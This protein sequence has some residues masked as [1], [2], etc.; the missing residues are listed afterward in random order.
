LEELIKLQKDALINW[1][2]KPADDTRD[3]LAINFLFKVG[4]EYQNLKPSARNQL[5]AIFRGWTSPDPLSLREFTSMLE[6]LRDLIAEDS[7]GFLMSDR[8]S[9]RERLWRQKARFFATLRRCI[10]SQDLGKVRPRYTRGAFASFLES[11]LRNVA[12]RLA[13]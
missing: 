13:A 8:R 4:R 7:K 2:E 12:D 5:D 6:T 11:A 9:L 1:P 10:S 3:W